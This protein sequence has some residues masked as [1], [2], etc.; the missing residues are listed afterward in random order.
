MNTQAVAEH[1][2]QWIAQQVAA[3]GVKGIAVGLSGGIDSAV[4][5][6]LAQ[7]ACGQNVIG[8]IMPCHSDSGDAEDARIVA[9]ELGLATRTVD[10][11]STYD[12]LLE[13]MGVVP[14]GRTLALANIKP[15]LRMTTLYYHAQSMGYLVAGTGNRSELTIG[16]FTKHGDGG[17][18]IL[19]IGGLVKQ[20]VWDLARV[21][22]IPAKIIDKAPSAGLWPDQTDEK[23]MGLSYCELDQYILTGKG[24]EAVQQRVEKLK[25]G[26]AHKR[27]LPPIPEV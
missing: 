1:L 7:K 18:D 22:G 27:R 11:S 2:V 21:L 8:I 14:Q 6:A 16:Y 25:A 13:A 5:A 4:V 24:T 9:D 10:L 12:S 26:A 19:P 15:R 23:E 17:C 3:A 20:Q